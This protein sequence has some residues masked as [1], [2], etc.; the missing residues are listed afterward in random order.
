MTIISNFQHTSKN[1][2]TVLNHLPSICCW[3]A[4]SLQ[5]HN[6]KGF[7]FFFFLCSANFRYTMFTESDGRGRISAG[8]VGSDDETPEQPE[9]AP[10]DRLHR[11]PLGNMISI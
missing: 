4:G 7:F 8:A 10:P 9:T 2:D 5:K 3:S 11:P 6:V 1:L